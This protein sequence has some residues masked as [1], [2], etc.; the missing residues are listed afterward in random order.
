MKRIKLI[1]GIALLLA[2]L[3]AALASASP[4][5][6]ATG[7]LALTGVTGFNA[8]PQGQT[9]I[10]ELE[11]IHEYSG[12]IEATCEVSARITAHGPC[13]VDAGEVRENWLTCDVCEGRVAGREGTFKVQQTCQVDPD[14][15]PNTVCLGVLSGV[16]DLSNL[17]GVL[18]GKG[19]AGTEGA[20]EGF[21]HFDPE[22]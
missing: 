6:N 5:I 21:I 13:P 10:I 7:T 16:G 2:L 9:C 15:D 19:T 12:T 17:H 8:Y 3:P 22:P 1:A 14:A 4:P 11:G 20:Y 18:H